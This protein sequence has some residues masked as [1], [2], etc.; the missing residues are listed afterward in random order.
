MVK[1]DVELT[2]TEEM[3]G[4]ASANPD[5]YQEFI[6]SKCAE[7]ATADEVESLPD[8]DEMVEKGTTVFH[9]LDGKPC[10]FDYQIKGFFKD[11]C[12]ALRRCDET[13]SKKLTAFKKHIDGTVF[14][15]PRMIP[16]ELPEGAAM[17]FC[18]RPLRAQTAQGERV[19]LARSESIPAGS[20]I[21]FVVALLAKDTIGAVEEWLDYGKLR[22]LGQW[23]NSGK[24]RFTFTI[25]KVEGE[26]VVG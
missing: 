17:G 25:K 4:T 2:L 14:V 16:V 3:L 18:T 26:K 11:A 21:R 12:G 6:A 8:A 9:R 10:L 19:S 24:G 23:R 15:E 1:Y 22:G 7:E 13:L 5:I 20:V